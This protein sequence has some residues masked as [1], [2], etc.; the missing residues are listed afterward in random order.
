MEKK[1]DAVEMPRLLHSCQHAAPD[2][3]HG[4][5]KAREAMFIAWVSAISGVCQVRYRI[6]SFR[7]RK[8][9]KPCPPSWVMM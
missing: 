4:H 6:S 2:I 5:G 1:L 9:Y 8:K 7:F 3:E